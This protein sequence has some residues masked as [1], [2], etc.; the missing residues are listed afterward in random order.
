MVPLHKTKKKNKKH[1][2]VRIGVC[3][4]CVLY[5]KKPNKLDIP[6]EGGKLDQPLRTES[7]VIYPSDREG[8]TGNRVSLGLENGHGGGKNSSKPPKGGTKGKKKGRKIEVTAK[9]ETT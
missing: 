6:Q 2:R 7:L 4:P 1:N 5:E 8:T 9:L 3:C